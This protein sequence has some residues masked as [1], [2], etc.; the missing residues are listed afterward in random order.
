M[1]RSRKPH[2]VAQVTATKDEHIDFSDIPELDETFWQDA[3]LVEADSTV[4]IT[5]RVKRS[6]L[7]YFRAL[8]KGLPNADQPRARKLRQ[9]TARVA[10]KQSGL[11]RGI[12]GRGDRPVAPT[13]TDRERTPPLPWRLGFYVDTIFQLPSGWRQAV[14]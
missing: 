3:E 2:T 6:V 13:A 5:M 1:R 11:L 8:G 12:G 7:N 14:P 10:M 9:G 4:R